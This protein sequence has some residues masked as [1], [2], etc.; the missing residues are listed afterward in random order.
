MESG[1][2]DPVWR[3]SSPTSRLAVISALTLEA[4]IPKTVL[5]DR[6]PTVYVCGP[7]HERAFAAAK[8]A[9]AAGAD[10]LIAW[11]LAGGLSPQAGTAAVV[12]PKTVV[13]D[14]QTWRADS[15]WRDRLAL[16]LGSEFQLIEGPLY[17]ADRVLTT[18]QAKAA[19]AARSGAV[20]VDMESAAVA[21][22]AAESGLP[23]VALRVIADGPRDTLPENVE[24]LVTE[25][26][27]TCYRSLVGFI[28]SP[29]RLRLLLNLA[30][31]SRDARRQLKRVIE[32]LVRSA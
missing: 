8:R 13:R 14:A 7:G 30:G 27:Q 21:K 22:A 11:G 10:A 24:A 16:V 31:K 28:G 6:C 9:I 17:S 19:L 23:C 25:K 5:G 29:R 4:R 32:V 26:G 18:P 2:G 15:A 12:L 3:S 20:A 1:T